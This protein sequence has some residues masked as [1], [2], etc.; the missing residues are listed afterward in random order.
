MTSKSEKLSI[1]ETDDLIARLSSTEGGVA[2]PAFEE[3][4]RRIADVKSRVFYA[5]NR[6]DD[7]NALSYLVELLG[8]SRDAK[9]FPFIARQ[10]ESEH[11]R[12]R[13]FA[14]AALRSLGTPESRELHQGCDLRRL[15]F[16]ERP[17][18]K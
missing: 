3:L 11:V 18:S 9:Y 4:R 10:L 7:C 13:F 1:V 16:D 2:E 15:L 6:E 12:V 5:A 17:R 8:E 14:H